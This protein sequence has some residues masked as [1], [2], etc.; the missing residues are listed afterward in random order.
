MLAFNQDPLF[1]DLQNPL[2]KIETRLTH[3]RQR[4]WI[5]KERDFFWFWIEDSPDFFGLFC[6]DSP[7]RRLSLRRGGWFEY[8]ATLG[9]GQQLRDILKTQIHHGDWVRALSFSDPRPDKSNIWRV[10][11]RRRH[12]LLQNTK[13]NRAL[14]FH[15]ETHWPAKSPHWKEMKHLEES[16]EFFAARF[17]PLLLERKGRLSSA[18]DFLEMPVE[19]HE[20]PIRFGK[21]TETEFRQVLRAAMITYYSW[22]EGLKRAFRM[23]FHHRHF[24]PIYGSMALQLHTK[25]VGGYEFVH[26]PQDARLSRLADTFKPFLIEGFAQHSIVP[27]PFSLAA[28]HHEPLVRVEVQG[29]FT[30]HELLEAHLTVRDWLAINAPELLPEL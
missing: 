9:S 2:L 25:F 28:R 27:T 21:G 7:H 20:N 24:R 26:E 6:D 5:W 10:L 30:H 18:F 4:W 13:N 8:A 16:A 22:P 23:R 14:W 1:S 15:P 19:D 29:P 3:G 11:W 12:F 17:W